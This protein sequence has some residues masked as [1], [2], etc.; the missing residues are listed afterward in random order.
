[1]DPHHSVIRTAKP[2][3]VFDLAELEVRSWRAS[4]GSIFP[5][6]EL[7]KMSVERR[8]ISWAR[9]LEQTAYQSVALVAEADDGVVG[10]LQAGPA[11]GSNTGRIGE[12]Y[13]IYVDPERWGRGIGTALMDVTFD[14]M[15]P[16][17]EK[18]VLWVVRENEKARRFYEARG[19]HEDT[20]NLK[21]YTFFNYAVLCARYSRSLAARRLLD[22]SVYLGAG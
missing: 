16:R 2:T 13:S 10:F 1:M 17:F 22:W 11:R 21:T 15:A 9:T 12:I 3:D 14:F 19:F 4:Y 6:S 18:A 5:A 20:G 7:Q 8:A